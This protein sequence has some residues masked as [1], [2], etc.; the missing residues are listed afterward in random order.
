MYT[1]EEM[2]KM[3]HTYIGLDLHKNTHTAVAMNCFSKVSMTMEIENKP[4]E[5]DR[6][7]KEVKSKHKGRKLIFGLEDVGGNGRSLAVYLRDK[8][9]IVKEVNAALAAGYRKGDA[10]YQKND[11][12]DA[13]CVAEVLVHK[14]DRLPDANPQDL[15]WTLSQLVA[16]R[17]SLVKDQTK[18]TNML[19]E[20]LKHHYPSYRK[21]F[22]DIRG[23]AAMCFWRTYPSP[24]HLENVSVEELAE[25]MRLASRN[26]VSTKK[27][28]RIKELIET[29]GK[30]T[31]GFQ[32]ERDMLVRDIVDDITY[33]KGKIE[34]VEQQMAK[35][36]SLLDYQLQTM[37]GIS[38]V[39]SCHL[40][41]E[42]GD[43]SRF[44]NPD[45]LAK[46]AG[47]APVNFSSAGKGNDK[48][49]KQGN[50]TLH[51]VFYFLAVQ[52]VQVAK[53]TKIPR[54]HAFYNYYQ[55]KLK[56]GKTKQQALVCVMRRLVNIIHGMMR[57][58]TAYR[59]PVVPVMQLDQK[60]A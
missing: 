5:F 12:H 42:I 20:T 1:N 40:I 24:K 19:H 7:V 28:K 39:V 2:E 56:E 47:I 13:Q 16:R 21:F 44:S 50:R 30:T 8:G 17:K 48:K 6:L 34:S 37:P 3:N 29:D 36:E 27:A 14:L 45:K 26:S 25:A 41:S 18:A 43:I 51:G 33:Y 59:M 55:K 10:Q 58:K 52:Q 35:V 38:T 32:E 49:S 11:T 54:N 60:T 46:F 22:S 23:K 15:Y 4:S 53:S 31:D 57:T 9:Y